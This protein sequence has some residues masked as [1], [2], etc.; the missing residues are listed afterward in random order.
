MITLI[1][2]SRACPLARGGEPARILLHHISW[3]L[4]E[5]L[6]A[7]EANWGI[8]MA[9]C[10][11]DL[12]LMSPGRVHE[13]YGE[14]FRHFVMALAHGVGFK[15]KGVGAWTLVNSESEK[16]KEPDAAYYVQNFQRIQRKKI[17]LKVDPPP[18]IAFEAE[19]SRSAVNS[20][21]IYAA[22]R[23]PEIWRFDGEVLRIHVCQV[24]GG[25][26]ESEQ[27]LAFPFLKPG[28]FVAWVQKADELDDDELWTRQIEEWA[29]VEL[30]PRLDRG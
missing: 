20:L 30:T 13:E 14:R 27:S 12:E 29:R 21:N 10:D 2:D 22:I 7:D 17:D 23:V 25:Y 18:D 6:R 3:R 28:E 24:D 26:Q 5:E 8:R 19:V 15:I 1:P 16:A 4:Y 11:G 9:Y